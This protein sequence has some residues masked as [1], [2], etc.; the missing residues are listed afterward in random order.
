MIDAMQNELDRY[1]LIKKLTKTS[2]TD[3]KVLV[4]IG[5]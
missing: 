2:K 3:H 4:L 5:P 1:K